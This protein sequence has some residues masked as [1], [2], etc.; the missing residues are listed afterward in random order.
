MDMEKQKS[1]KEVNKKKIQSDIT[2]VE[3]FYSNQLKFLWEQYIKIIQLILVLSG[4]TIL[5]MINITMMGKKSEEFQF[6]HPELAI[7]SIIFAALAGLFALGWRFSAQILMERQ[8]YGDKNAA[9]SYFKLTE[10]T[11]PWALKL[12]SMYKLE[13]FSEVFKYLSGPTLLL[14]WFVF[15]YFIVLNIY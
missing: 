3:N 13:K 2:S 11:I 8:V 5:T 1:N 15:I 6:T 10:T 9:I 4:L 12:K 14:S 7:V